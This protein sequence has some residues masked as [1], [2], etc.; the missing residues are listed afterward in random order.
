MWVSAPF[1]S[2]D[3]RSL[4]KADAAVLLDRQQGGRQKLLDT[5]VRMHSIF[6]VAEVL[7]VLQSNGRISDAQVDSVKQF[8]KDNQF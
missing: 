8:V 3:H 5:G 2:A 6:T 4:A 1:T 7:A